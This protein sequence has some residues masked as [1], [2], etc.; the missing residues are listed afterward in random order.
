MERIVIVLIVIIKITVNYLNFIK[1]TIT[2]IE[3]LLKINSL[4]NTKAVH[5]ENQDVLKNIVNAIKLVCFVER[6]ASVLSVKIINR[7]VIKK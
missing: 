4:E 5:V 7:L 1:T 2:W 6:F 3:K